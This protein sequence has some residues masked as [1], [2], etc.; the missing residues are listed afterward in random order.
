MLSAFS[1]LYNFIICLAAEKKKTPWVDHS[2]CS[3]AGHGYIRE[4]SSC[5]FFF[6]PP[7]LSKKA[8]LLYGDSPAVDAKY[9]SA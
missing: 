9:D 3:K 2:L 7:N 8:H 1:C 6:H 5:S 4:L